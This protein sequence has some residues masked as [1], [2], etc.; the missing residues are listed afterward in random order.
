MLERCI[1]EAA[2]RLR[3]N[4]EPYLIATV[5]SVRGSAYRQPGARML[6]TRDRFIAGS[7]SGG[8][9]EGDVQRRGWWRTETG[10]PAL[11]TYDSRVADDAEDD[12]LR[13]AFAVGCNGVIEILIE[14]AREGAI[15]P[16]AVAA[17]CLRS[18]R[19]GAVAVV[20]RGLPGSRGARTADGGLALDPELA[21]LPGLAAAVTHAVDAAV[22]TGVSSVIRIAAAE[23][24]AAADVDVFVE[25][26]VPPPR[27]FVFG[28]GPDA[29]P[30]V[31]LAR[32]LG[33]EVCV[34]APSARPQ[35]HERFAAADALLS[36]TPAELAAHV[37]AADRGLALVMAH[38]LD[39]DREQ[40]GALLGSRAAY[41]GVLGPRSRTNQ[42]LAQLD[43][44][45]D[46]RLHAPVGLALGAETPQEIALAIV[47]E[48]QAALAGSTGRSLR[49]GR[50][51]IHPA[52]SAPV[53]PA[54]APRERVA[55]TAA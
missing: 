18:Q 10:A 54:G 26:V 36:G 19:R 6:M 53:L 25:A 35:H 12:D 11:V 37:D 34:C 27:L 39:I 21:A 3:A 5:V 46:A 43:R 15:D 55:C 41:I 45:A 22:S 51:A 49:D 31:L 14:R 38:D 29:V 50:G 13:A 40:L 24:D 8:C 33:W 42:M 44:A 7:V 30:V 47:A 9:L 4:R 32:S 2:A 52:Q 1:V 16:L 28:T 20:F 17:E 23:S 48:A